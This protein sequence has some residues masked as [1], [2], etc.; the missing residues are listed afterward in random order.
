MAQHKGGLG[1]G[2]SALIPGGISA[3]QE[4]SIA[5]NGIIEIPLDKIIP[6]KNQ[7]RKIFSQESLTELADSIR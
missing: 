5:K 2:L 6:N 3:T 1:R 7:P 4:E